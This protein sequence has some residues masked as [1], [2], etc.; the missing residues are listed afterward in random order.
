MGRLHP[1]R[2][3][4]VPVPRQQLRHVGGGGLDRMQC[5]LHGG[6]PYA[7]HSNRPSG[8]DQRDAHVSESDRGAPSETVRSACEVDVEAASRSGLKGVRF[9][10]VRSLLSALLS[11]FPRLR[12]SCNINVSRRVLPAYLPFRLHIL[13]SY[14]PLHSHSFFI[15]PFSFSLSSPYNHLDY[16]RR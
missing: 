4:Y 10:F 6:D 7:D 9:R 8:P 14:V 2:W 15:R 3:K 11:P 12:K 1:R 5:N 13:T 16:N